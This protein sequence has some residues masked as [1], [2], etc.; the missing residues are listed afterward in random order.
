MVAYCEDGD[1]GCW[2]RFAGV[3]VG[4]YV[5]VVVAVVVLVLVGGVRVVANVTP[6]VSL[7]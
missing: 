3:V 4:A 2:G 5:V 1:A 7:R 6:A